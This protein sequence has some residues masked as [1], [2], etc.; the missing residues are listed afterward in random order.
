MWFSTNCNRSQQ[1]ID[2]NRQISRISMLNLWFCIIGSSRSA[3]YQLVDKR[4]PSF[5]PI[6]LTHCNLS[7][8]YPFFLKKNTD[9]IDCLS[10][11]YWWIDVEQIGALIIVDCRTTTRQRKHK[12]ESKQKMEMRYELA[13]GSRCWY[14][15]GSIA[16]GNAR[17]NSS[18]F[19][20]TFEPFDEKKN[21]LKIGICNFIKKNEIK[22]PARLMSKV[23]ASMSPYIISQQW[24]NEQ[25][26]KYIL[27]QR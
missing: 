17:V 11:T 6:S 19:R 12:T 26:K 7:L 13:R 9:L 24:F 5:D 21:C 14:R 10:I 27:K 25:W 2:W 20:R 4:W 22:L 23:N 18:Q 8:R 3:L 1:R 16:S 15:D